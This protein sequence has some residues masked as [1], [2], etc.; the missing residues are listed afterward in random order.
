MQD[1]N[2]SFAH[3]HAAAPRPVLECLL[4]IAAGRNLDESLA[5]FARVPIETYRAIGADRLTIN[6]PLTVIEGGNDE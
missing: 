2:V 6:L 1:G 4:E 3:L 5:D